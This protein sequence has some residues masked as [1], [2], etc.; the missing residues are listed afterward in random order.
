MPVQSPVRSKVRTPAVLRRPEPRSEVKREL[1]MRKA[2]TPKVPVVVPV[3]RSVLPVR[4]VEARFT[5]PT[6]LR[7]PEMVD[8]PVTASDVDVAMSELMVAPLKV[9]PPT[10]LS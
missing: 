9:A 4:V 3:V 5:F 1:L 8:D 7:V 10:A 6:A 2:P